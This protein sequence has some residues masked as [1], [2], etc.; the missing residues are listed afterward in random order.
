MRRTFG[1]MIY[2]RPSRFI[3]NIPPDVL[4]RNEPQ[5]A[6]SDTAAPAGLS[7]GANVRHPTF[8]EGVILS[9]EGAGDAMR[10]AV[11][12]RRA[13]TKRL[14]LKYAALEAVGS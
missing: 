6:V 11:Q 4:E 8:G 1:D 5:S 9:V 10:V 7:I 3:A 14:M 12:F 2:P 13:G